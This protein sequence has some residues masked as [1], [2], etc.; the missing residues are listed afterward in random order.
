MKLGMVT[1]MLYKI[2]DIGLSGLIA[3]GIG[4]FGLLILLGFATILDDW[5]DRKDG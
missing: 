3:I 4:S 1:M 2:I 5:R